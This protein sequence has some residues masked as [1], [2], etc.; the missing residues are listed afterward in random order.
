MES[1]DLDPA[2]F[3]KKSFLMQNYVLWFLKAKKNTHLQFKKRWFGL[4][5]FWFYFPN[6]I[7]LLI[8]MDKFDP[9]PILVNIK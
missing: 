6:N 9:K 3:Q 7:I 1:C 4:C 8:I 5:K 2:T